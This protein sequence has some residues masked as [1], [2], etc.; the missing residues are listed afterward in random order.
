MKRQLLL[1]TLL[2]LLPPLLFSDTQSGP[3]SP[4]TP[5]TPV[6]FAQGDP[7]P[8]C[9]FPPCPT[10][11][12]AKPISDSNSGKH[13][14]PADPRGPQTTELGSGILLLSLALILMWKLRA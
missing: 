13:R 3:Q 7:P 1:A 14:K 11:R 10:S 4:S 2:L 5:F 9:P 8:S 6:A 12:L